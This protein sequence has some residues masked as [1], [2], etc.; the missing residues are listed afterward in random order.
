[1][2]HVLGRWHRGRAALSSLPF[3]LFFSSSDV[4]AFLSSRG[5]KNPSGNI[6]LYQRPDRTI[7]DCHQG[8]FIGYF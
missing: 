2:A 1:M 7:Y 3:S 5:F 8:R 4:G 6:Q